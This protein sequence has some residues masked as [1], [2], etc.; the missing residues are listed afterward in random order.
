MHYVYTQEN[1]G[2]GAAI[3]HGWDIAAKESS[4]LGFVDAD[5]A[6]GA[7][8][9]WR[10]A[11][12]LPDA[13]CDALCG[14]RLP[15][16]GRSI[17]RSMFRAL[18]GRAFARI[19]EQLFRLGC[20]DTQCGLKFFRAEFLRPVLN[21]LREERWLLDIEV[22]SHLR[23]AGADIVETPIDCHERGGSALVFGLDAIRMLAGLFALRA[24]LPRR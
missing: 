7:S 11:A 12:R 15:M 21:Q 1:Q 10:I 23:A 13:S 17:E 5:G 24:R 18:Q 22:L 4:W 8:E 6:V 2:K 19:V 16:A 3:R 20:F 14:I 9:Y